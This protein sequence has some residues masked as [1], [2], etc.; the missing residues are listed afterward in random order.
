M[1][2]LK[3]FESFI[4]TEDLFQKN[5]KLII[6]V[7][8]GIDS[9]VLCELCHQAKFNFGIAHCNFQLR[10]PE[11]ERDEQ[12]VKELS[13]KYRVQVFVKKF[14]TEKYALKNRMGIQE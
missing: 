7:S 8:G 5:D 3:S 13:G 9:V 6:A 12:F 1:I 11:S 4:S 14:E 10:G 2:L